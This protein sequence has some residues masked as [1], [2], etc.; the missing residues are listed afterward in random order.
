MQI[1]YLYIFTGDRTRTDTSLRS[2]DF[3]SIVSTN[4]TTPADNRCHTTRIG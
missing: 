1:I 2:I 4:F 3:E